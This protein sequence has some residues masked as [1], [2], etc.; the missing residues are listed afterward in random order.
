FRSLFQG[1]QPVPV[2]VHDITTEWTPRIKTEEEEYVWPPSPPRTPPRPPPIPA[3]RGRVQRRAGGGCFA[4][5]RAVIGWLDMVGHWALALCQWIVWLGQ[6]IVQLGSWLGRGIVWLG[7]CIVQLGC[8]LGCGFAWLISLV[9]G[10][11]RCIVYPIHAMTGRRLGGWMLALMLFLAQGSPGVRHAATIMGR[12]FSM[13]VE[14]AAANRC[15]SWVRTSSILFDLNVTKPPFSWTPSQNSM[16]WD[17]VSRED[18]AEA[19]MM[20]RLNLSQGVLEEWNRRGLQGEPSGAAEPLEHVCQ[21]VWARIERSAAIVARRSFVEG[22]KHRHEVAVEYGEALGELLD[23]VSA[24]VKDEA[25]PESMLD[26]GWA[27]WTSTE[28]WWRWC[29]RWLEAVSPA[30]MRRIE[31]A[32]EQEQMAELAWRMREWSVTREQPLLQLYRALARAPSR[33]RMLMAV[34]REMTWAKHWMDLLPLPPNSSISNVTVCGLSAPTIERTRAWVEAWPCI[35]II[36]PPTTINTADSDSAAHISIASIDDKHGDGDNDGDFADL[37]RG[38]ADATCDKDNNGLNSDRLHKLLQALRS[39]NAFYRAPP[40]RG[41]GGGGVRLEQY[42]TILRLLL[43]AYANLLLLCI[44]VAATNATTTTAPTSVLHWSWPSFVDDPRHILP[45]N[46]TLAQEADQHLLQL[47]TFS[48]RYSIPWLLDIHHPIPFTTTSSDLP[49]YHHIGPSQS[50]HGAKLGLDLS[51]RV[52]KPFR[53]LHRRLKVLSHQLDEFEW[54]DN[55]HRCTLR[56]STFR[57]MLSN[58]YCFLTRH[59]YLFL[60]NPVGMYPANSPYWLQQAQTLGQRQRH[61]L[62][63]YHDLRSPSL[64][65]KYERIQNRTTAYRSKVMESLDLIAVR[66]MQCHR[67]G[68]EAACRSKFAGEIEALYRS[69]AWVDWLELN[70]FVSYHRS[71]AMS[72]FALKMR[73]TLDRLMDRLKSSPASVDALQ[74]LIEFIEFIR[75][76]NQSTSN[77]PTLL[78]TLGY[79]A[80][81]YASQHWAHQHDKARARSASYRPLDFP[82]NLDPAYFSQDFLTCLLNLRNAYTV[83]SSSHLD[84]HHPSHPLTCPNFLSLQRNRHWVFRYFSNLQLSTPSPPQNGS[85]SLLPVPEPLEPHTEDWNCESST[86]RLPLSAQGLRMGNVPDGRKREWTMFKKQSNGERCLVWEDEE[87]EDW[88]WCLEGKEGEGVWAYFRKFEDDAEL[89]PPSERFR[90]MLLKRR[91][92]E[93]RLREEEEVESSLLKSWPLVNWWRANVLEPWR[94]LDWWV[95]VLDTA[96]AGWSWCIS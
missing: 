43:T 65:S 2:E 30:M 78:H 14:H 66:I 16:A 35:L 74:S 42:S 3:G 7:Q 44:A 27:S 56:C 13:P 21:A 81:L 53:P 67:Q 58:L 48:P 77:G 10:I 32:Q 73:A 24:V 89:L 84:Y 69:K 11:G 31:R 57:Q 23:G 9:D 49:V 63:I 29:R 15:Y 61:E 17:S 47:S 71:S 5:L 64:L 75:R 40:G 80:G 52:C 4:W 39:M 41:S 87:E 28:R 70:A 45:F 6:C 19:S 95:Y 25:E 12:A 88:V 76:L 79:R 91:K 68:P 62:S 20:R 86:H 92:E 36:L 59:L 22:M 90:R 55:L 37:F 93:K 54:L 82:T 96:R 50:S 18:A 83:T 51:R 26:H 38:I 46:D 85:G 60:H 94:M 34:R 33:N 72:F 1:G 8:W